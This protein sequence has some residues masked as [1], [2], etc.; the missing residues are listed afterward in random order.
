MQRG[1]FFS[2]IACGAVAIALSACVE[3]PPI[4]LDPE[5]RAARLEARSLTDPDV[6]AALN[7]AGLGAG[8]NWTLD[9]LTAAAW[10]LRPDFAR[11]AADV[12][13]ADAAEHAAGQ[14]QNPTFSFD[15]QYLY[16]NASGNISPW[17][18]AASLGFTIETGGK[19]GIRVA[20]SRAE[21]DVRRWQ[22][23]EAAWK[24]RQDI[25]K[26][27]TARLVAQSALTLTRREAMLRQSFSI[28]VENALR[29]GAVGQ[30]ERLSAVTTLAQAQTAARTATGDAAAADATLAL[31]VGVTTR[32]FP[33]TSLAPLETEALP[34]PE[35]LDMPTLRAAALTN[36]LSLRRAL[37]EYHVTEQ[38]LRMEVAKQYPD[39]S[40]GP[41]YVYDKGDRGVTLTLGF[42]LPLFHGARAVIDQALA[43]RAKAAVQFNLEQSQALNEIETGSVRYAA[44]YA[45]WIEAKNAEAA[46]RKAAEA[47]DNR[48]AMGSA[49]RSEVLT[50]SLAQVAVERATLNALRAAL[51]ALGTIED[52]VQRPVW[53]ISAL[54][55][56][57]PDLQQTALNRN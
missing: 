23:A 52:S 5:A 35:M 3:A 43:A 9:R 49:D 44:A 2:A 6:N 25:R 51:E 46:S 40:F 53:P 30:P 31:A 26:A 8:T 32:N 39:V 18:L 37:A 28:W 22:L 10:S 17:T 33:F 54:T 42:T 45:A 16:D 34:E 11:A 21:T 20:Q 19:R 14:L 4:A 36:R 15:P 12:L 41:G 1:R 48:L 50:A 56:P 29:F 38:A 47:A 24:M 7:K 55:L 27:L 13:A 57:R